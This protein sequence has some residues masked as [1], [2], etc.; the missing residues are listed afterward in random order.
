MTTFSWT[1]MMHDGLCG[2]GKI[3]IGWTRDDAESPKNN[4]TKNKI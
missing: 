2:Q 1:R 4:Y 3:I